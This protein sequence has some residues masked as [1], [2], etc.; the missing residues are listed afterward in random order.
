MQEL[1][2]EVR[3]LLGPR[4]PWHVGDVAWG[5]RQHAG[6]ER[7]W[8]IRLWEHDGRVVAWSWLKTDRG[9]LELDV[10]P[11]HRQLID[12]L[13]DE[14][15]A[16]VA[17]A[18]E[19]D[20]EHRAALARHGFTR[21]GE[22]MDYNMR[23]LEQ[24][25]PAR[26]LPEGFRLRTV[27]PEDLAER[28]ALH[29]DVWA[30]VA[31]HRGELRQR[32]ADVAVPR[33][34]RLRG[35]STG[36]ALCLLHA[37]LARRRERRRRARAGRHAGGVSPPRTGRRRLRLRAAP[38]ARTG[39]PQGDRLFRYRACPGALP[40]GWLPLPRQADRFRAYLSYP[41]GSAARGADIRSVRIE[42]P[43]SGA[44]NQLVHDLVPF[45]RTDL[46]PLEDDRW[47]VRVEESTEEELDAVLLAV[48]RWASACD[49]PQGHVLVDGEPAEL[50]DAD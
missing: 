41:V 8:R 23:A 50:P 24:P 30:P 19:D 7:E 9:R 27:E 31:R 11:E 45:A 26:R 43:T 42:A 38:L 20:E 37:A 6:R 17:F 25:P 22:V 18:F 14:P 1:A 32:D 13:L 15:D 35:G 44:A 3:R 34:A 21:P 4:A 39:R 10:H 2:L 33:F 29:R 36:R 12:E 16:R 48:A 47:E 49:V 46:L 40:P 28:V 5:L